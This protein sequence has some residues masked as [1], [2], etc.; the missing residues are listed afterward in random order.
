MKNKEK[1]KSKKKL[2]ITLGI[3]VAVVV[4][5]VGAQQW[6]Y[7]IVSTPDE[8]ITYDTTNPYIVDKA[9]VSAHRS[10]G[11]IM[12]E[13]TMMAFKNCVENENF[14]TDIFEFDLHIT[15]D[16]VLV[17]LHDDTLDRTS[18]CVEVFGEEDVRPENKTF[19][20]LLQL[21][22][23]AKF[24]DENGNMP[25]ANLKGDDVPDDLRIVSLDQILDYLGSAGNYD[26]IIEIKNGGDL[27]KQAADIL[28]TTLEERDL[29]ERVV[30]GTFKGEISNYVDEKYP[31]LMRSSSI[32]EVVSFYFKA[33]AGA[34]N[35]DVEYV[36]LQIPYKLV[37]FNLGTA[38]VINYAHQN[39]LAVQYWTINDEADIEYLVSIGADCII[40]DY[41]DVAYEIV[42]KVEK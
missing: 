31:D 22:M 5:L 15:K 13:E 17:L 23:G 35:L 11:G 3:V 41:P 33:L 19:D 16:G 4:A 39:N 6:A 29:L 12:P 7:N 28:Y 30:F 40:S 21:N 27:G 8:I 14:N 20:E 42:E 24:E 1:K 10:G 2:F 9:L 38:Q 37:G 18:D 32:V 25:Y 36:A 34:D 26:Y